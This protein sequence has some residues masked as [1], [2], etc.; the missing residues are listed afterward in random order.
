MFN[1]ELF[2]LEVLFL[3]STLEPGGISV[4]LLEFSYPL[5]W[6]LIL[7]QPIANVH[8]ENWSCLW[9]SSRFQI[10]T[11][12]PVTIKISACFSFPS[13]IPLPRPSLIHNVCPESANVSR[14]QNGQQ[15]LAYRGNTY[16]FLEF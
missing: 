7:L 4:C 14:K 11:L 1:A 8:S 9:G 16:P 3:L 5:P 13:R 6:S 15:S 2:S 10:S 12:T